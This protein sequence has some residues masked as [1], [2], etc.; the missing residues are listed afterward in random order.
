M[1][2]FSLLPLILT[3]SFGGPTSPPFNPCDLDD[4]VCPNEVKTPMEATQGVKTQQGI[5]S[6]L[7]YRLPD[8]CA[9]RNYKKGTRLVVAAGPKSV[10]C[11]VRDFGPSA[12]VF[13]ERIIDLDSRLFQQLAPLSIGVVKVRIEIRE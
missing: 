9:T 11:V 8:S 10:T 12:T 1:S 6:W 13:P 2:P 3:L 5:A 4:I 7:H